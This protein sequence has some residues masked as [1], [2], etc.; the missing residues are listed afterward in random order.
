ME[1]IN[2]ITF[3]SS[4]VS[5][6][7]VFENLADIVGKYCGEGLKTEFMVACK[8][9]DFEKANTIL[10]KTVKEITGYDNVSD[11]LS[12]FADKFN[13]IE[14]LKGKM[15]ECVS[16]R[17]KVKAIVSYANKIND[18]IEKNLA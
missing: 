1:L 6:M 8:N 14:G 9:I 10:D 5:A 17:D 7:P 4:V 11:A 2:P 15:S 16:E 18:I 12:L 13:G 3:A